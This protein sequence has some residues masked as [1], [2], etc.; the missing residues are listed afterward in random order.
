MSD[1]ILRSTSIHRN[2]VQCLSSVLEDVAIHPTIPEEAQAHASAAG[3]DGEKCEENVASSEF[4][5]FVIEGG[6]RRK[7]KLSD[8][9]TVGLIDRNEAQKIAAEISEQNA[10]N[11]EQPVAIP[12]SLKP[13]L[14]GGSPVA[15]ILLSEVGE[16]KSIF[17]AAKDGILRR[18]M[19]ISLLEAQ[20][21]T[22]NIIDPITGRKISVTDAFQLGL[23]DKVYETVVSRAERAVTGYKSRIS[24]DVLSLGQAISRG[25]VIESHG[26]RLLEVQLA[27]GGIIDHKTN[28]RLP[29]EVAVKQGLLDKQHA[30]VVKEACSELPNE[31]KPD[32]LK[33]FF[34]PN[35]EEN[36]TYSELLKR[37][38]VDTETGIRLFPLEKIRARRLNCGNHSGR[39]SLASSRASS[40]ESIPS[41]VAASP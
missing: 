33:T 41:A 7:V 28:L 5:N 35:T 39:S 21:A 23:F 14:C 27:T 4:D 19:A 32:N 9:L 10:A 8:L 12:D 34:D 40:K 29:L 16:K 3:A 20:A 37:S 25:L 31:S 11:S 22:G 24:D 18:G 2:D 30:D 36:V 6:W 13:F 17:S 1:V 15:G 26:I 38:V